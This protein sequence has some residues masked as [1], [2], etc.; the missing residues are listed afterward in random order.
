[1]ADEKLKGVVRSYALDV[2]A[3]AD[4]T[5]YD[6]NGNPVIIENLEDWKR[7][8]WEHRKEKFLKEYEENHGTREL[9]FDRELFDTEEKF[10]EDEIGSVDDI[11]EP[12]RMSVTDYVDCNSLGDLRFEVDSRMEFCGGRALL[13]FGGPNVWLHDDEILGYWGGD[14]ETWTLSAGA[15]SALWEYFEENWNMLR[16]S[17]RR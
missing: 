8:E 6:V 10:L 17:Q 11:D 7:K 3:A 14:A 9:D 5:L 4:G 15:R 2:E 13:A 12:E 16:D 1:M